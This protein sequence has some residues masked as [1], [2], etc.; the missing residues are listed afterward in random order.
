MKKVLLVSV[1]LMLTIPVLALAATGEP[2]NNN[3][4][5]G[6][7]WTEDFLKDYDN[8]GLDR[9]IENALDE[10]ISPIEIMTF[11]ITSNEEFNTKSALKAL[12]CAAADTALVQEAAN[13]LGITVRE[14]SQALQESIA[15]CSSKMA[16]SDRDMEHVLSD[17]FISGQRETETITLD[18]RRPPRDPSSPQRP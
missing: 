3:H 6:I 7:A 13:K 1:Y 17:P 4:E 16:L 9:A 14:I 10:E 12:Y 5:Q 15:E 2:T 11:I 8:Y 18:D